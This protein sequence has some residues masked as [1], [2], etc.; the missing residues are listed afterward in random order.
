M[1]NQQQLETERLYLRPVTIE[2]ASDIYEYSKEGGYI[3]LATDCFTEPHKDGH[4][5]L[6]MTKEQFLQE[7]QKKFVII[8]QEENKFQ[9]HLCLILKKLV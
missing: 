2:D 4:P 8:K 9:R 1:N 7:I 3:A 6:G 5:I